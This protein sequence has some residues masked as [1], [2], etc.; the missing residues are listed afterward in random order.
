M[1][2]FFGPLRSSLTFSTGFPR[3]LLPG[4]PSPSSV[5][6]GGCILSPLRKLSAGVSVGTRAWNDICFESWLCR[7]IKLEASKE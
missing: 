5:S 3:A 6:S 4:I 7:V 1:W 2:W